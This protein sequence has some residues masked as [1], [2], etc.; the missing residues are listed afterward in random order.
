MLKCII[1]VAAF[2]NSGMTKKIQVQVDHP[3]KRWQNKTHVNPSW[4]ATLHTPLSGAGV[5]EDGEDPGPCV[6]PP[7]GTTDVLW[8]LEGS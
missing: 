7:E 4:R 1:H 5:R 8:S 2:Q 3:H 6:T